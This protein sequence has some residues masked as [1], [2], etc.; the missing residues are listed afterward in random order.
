MSTVN[1]LRMSQ[2]TNTWK[3]HWQIKMRVIMKFEQKIPEMPVT[4]T[5]FVF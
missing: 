2:N 4:I 1:Y 5:R 3:R